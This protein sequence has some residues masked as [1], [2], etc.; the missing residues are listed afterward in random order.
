MHQQKRA[1][2]TLGE[3]IVAVTDEVNCYVDDPSVK[4][5]MVSVVLSDL[6]AHD[7]VRLHRLAQELQQ[8][9]AEYRSAS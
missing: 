9:E 4:Y 2:T 3:L 5:A 7:R 1:T 6:F 8:E